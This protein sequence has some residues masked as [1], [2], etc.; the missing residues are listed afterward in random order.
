[1]TYPDLA[2]RAFITVSPNRCECG[3][4]R[5][6]FIPGMVSSPIERLAICHLGWL[7][8]YRNLECVLDIAYYTESRSVPAASVPSWLP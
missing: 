1:M 5:P 4:M 2:P 7:S 8:T 6:L 3:P